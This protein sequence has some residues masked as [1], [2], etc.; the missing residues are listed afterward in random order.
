MFSL[1]QGLPDRLYSKDKADKRYEGKERER[2]MP[3]ELPAHYPK[4]N[5]PKEPRESE[6]DGSEWPDANHGTFLQ[7]F[8]LDLPAIIQWLGGRIKHL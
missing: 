1:S 4:R 8:T 7:N 5:N 2:R 6:D 3:A